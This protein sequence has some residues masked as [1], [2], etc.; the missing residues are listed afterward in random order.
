MRDAYNAM[1]VSIGFYHC[2]DLT[3]GS[4][5]T[6]AAKVF[7]QGREVYFHVSRTTHVA[8][9][10]IIWRPDKVFKARILPH[11]GQAQF[12]NWTIT[13]FGD[14]DFCGSLIWTV[15]VINFIAINK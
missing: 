3:T 8:S 11:E 5:F 2:N 7:L 1:A 9:A 14:D 12:A 6:Y 10:L 15:I 4:K 13:L